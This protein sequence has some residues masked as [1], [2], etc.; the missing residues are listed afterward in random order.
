M[1]NNE[2]YYRTLLRTDLQRIQ[3][4]LFTGGEEIPQELQPAL[5][6]LIEG[7]GKRLRP[8]MA[9][10][11]TYLFD[12]GA[13][14]AREAAAA[15]EMLH[16]ATLVHDDL[17]DNAQLR[18]GVQTF[19]ANW[20][21]IATVLTGDLLF[22]RAAALVAETDN[23]PLVRR[24]SETL[25]V[26]SRGELQQMF[27]RNGAIPTLEAYY[28]RISAKTA[29]L[30]GLASEVGPLLTVQPPEESR[31]LRRFGELLGLS[32]QIVDD[33]LD[34]TGEVRTLGKPSGGD[35]RQ[36]I[37][38]LPVILYLEEHPQD[39]RVEAIVEQP[40]HEPL[41]AEFL[42]DLESSGALERTMR[43][44]HAHVDEALALLDRYPASPYRK[45]LIEIANFAVG[46]RY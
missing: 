21:T 34:F 19:N 42:Q 11:S 9:L 8:S 1:N 16:T 36:G 5:V 4:L 12:P 43:Q 23:L 15:I 18:R 46:R 31:R 24:F 40:A 41:I 10:L 13:E 38:T 22:S 27:G 37:V 6:A 45:A 32:F 14:R 35:L 26:I 7:G 28:E 39:R 17:V 2:L 25:S 33:L 30:F 20:G 44:A 29:S 3:Q